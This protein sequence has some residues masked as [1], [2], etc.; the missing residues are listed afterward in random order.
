[1]LKYADNHNFDF[2]YSAAKCLKTSKGAQCTNTVTCNHTKY[3]GRFEKC[4]AKVDWDNVF[5]NNGFDRAAVSASTGNPSVPTDPSGN[6]DVWI[7][8]IDNVGLHINATNSS[9]STVSV[10][11]K[12]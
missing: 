10:E 2:A 6:N 7:T 9:S 1:M 4:V 11:I 5:K 8:Q 3:D 12:Q